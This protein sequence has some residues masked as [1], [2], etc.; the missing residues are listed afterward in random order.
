MDVRTI[1]MKASNASPVLDVNITA[2]LASVDVMH[3]GQMITIMRNQNQ[4]NVVNPEFAKTSRKCP[5]FC[6]QP[7]ELAPGVKTIA[8]LEVLHFLQQINAGDASSM[9]IDSRTPDWV[10]K[11]TIPGSVNIPWDKLDIGKS[12]AAT[13]QDVLEKQLSVQGQ[14]GLWNFDSAK[15]LVMFCNGAWC[16]QSPTNIQAL[17]KIGYPAH[18]LFWYRGGMQDWESLGLTT[19]Q[20]VNK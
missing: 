2:D 3:D 19:A 1:A 12:D 7:S 9:V 17:L 13:V 16:G 6:I 20:P 15:T 4:T 11:G 14:N 5:P 18:K 10:E 8:E